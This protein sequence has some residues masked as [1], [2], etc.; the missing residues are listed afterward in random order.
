[1]DSIY[2]VVVTYAGE[3]CA[4]PDAGAGPGAGAGR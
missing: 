3:W 4:G 2:I 1:M